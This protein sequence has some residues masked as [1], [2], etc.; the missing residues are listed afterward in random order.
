MKRSYSALTE[1]RLPSLIN[2]VKH[3][4]SALGNRLMTLFY[5]HRWR[6]F[7]SAWISEADCSCL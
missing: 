2:I 3:S 7:C 6:T 4:N 1:G 5:R